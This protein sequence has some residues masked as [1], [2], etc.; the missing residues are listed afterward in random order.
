MYNCCTI[1]GFKIVL[2]KKP[3]RIRDNLLNGSFDQDLAA[4]REELNGKMQYLM[5]TLKSPV[6]KVS[7]ICQAVEKTEDMVKAAVT[8]S[9]VF[10]ARRLLNNSY[11]TAA[12]SINYLKVWPCRRVTSFKWRKVDNKCYQNVPV[13]YT[14]NVGGRI[15][16]G[17]L[18]GITRII[19]PSS[20]RVTCGSGTLSIL[21]ASGKL[22]IYKPG[23]VPVEDVTK[24]VL[25][26]PAIETENLTVN[27]NLPY[28][29]AYNDS[30]FIHVSSD[31]AVFDFINRRLS[32]EFSDDSQIKSETEGFG[33]IF[34][35]SNLSG[36]GIF[37]GLMTWIFRICAGLGMIA[38]LDRGR[39]RE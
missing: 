1:D 2:E 36:G 31:A 17:F 28:K 11:L 26:I 38:F 6:E 5:D 10:Y 9:P 3:Q 21:E 32:E 19:H 20:P 39:N 33:E 34:G 7:A 29:W 15:R 16:E 18:E 4:L 27:F 22:W 12:M 25:M 8:T 24:G 35:F 30:D 23:E 37:N 13:Y 14:L